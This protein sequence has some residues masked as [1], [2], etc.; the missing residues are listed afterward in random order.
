MSKNNSIYQCPV[1][2]KPLP[3]ISN[4]NYS[5]ANNHNF[6]I[7]SPGYVNLLLAHH[8]KTKDPGDT[9]EMLLS[10]RSFLEKGFYQ[11]LS[12]IINQIILKQ[13][14]K[15]PY[16]LDT[17]CGEGY[18][19]RQLEEKSKSKNY[20]FGIDISKS[21][22]TLAAKKSKSIHWAVGSNYN[23]PYLDNTFDD[24]ICIFS[25]IDP[26]EFH[27]ILKTQGHLIIIKP[28]KNHLLE[29]ASLIYNKI[30][31]HPEHQKEIINSKL[32]SLAK[33]E[34]LKYS[35]ELTNKEDIKNLLAMTP[36]FWSVC[37]EKKK[38]LHTLKNP[39]LQIDFQI[40]VFKKL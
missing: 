15:N 33:Q 25:P 17:G 24:I 14:R 23:L 13:T 31:P 36:Y 9:K 5:C 1:C 10:R 19:L 22:I 28:G 2:H 11:P 35:I 38:Q 6:D 32:F 20:L 8:K 3:R 40:D 18:Y 7:A 29:L 34:N 4:K 26:P 12:D 37:E 30:Q 39:K 21:A 16:I 27:R